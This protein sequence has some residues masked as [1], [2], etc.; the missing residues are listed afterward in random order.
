MDKL[1]F[2]FWGRDGFN[3]LALKKGTA[4]LKNRFK[5]EKNFEEVHLP[6]CSPIFI[7]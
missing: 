1:F 3:A 7:Q 6:T 4:V 2:P 5:K